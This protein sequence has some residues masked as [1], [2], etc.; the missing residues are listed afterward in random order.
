MLVGHLANEAV[1]P[2]GARGSRHVV[3]L[4]PR[5]SGRRR[6]ADEDDLRAVERCDR[7]GEAVP[8][9][10]ADEHRRAAPGSIEGTD[11]A[12]PFDEPFFVEQPVRREKYF[13]MDVTNLRVSCAE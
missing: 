5:A 6:R 1:P 10:F 13:A 7:P 2:A 11:L 12:A 4:R 3:G 9:V 8:R